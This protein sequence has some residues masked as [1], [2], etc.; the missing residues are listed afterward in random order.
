LGLIDQCSQTSCKADFQS[1]EL[2][3]GLL[4]RLSLSSHAYDAM[5][6]LS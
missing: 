1:P 5:F 2:L 6:G 3:F 4:Q